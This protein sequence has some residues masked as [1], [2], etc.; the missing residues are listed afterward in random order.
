VLDP[1]EEAGQAK[2][3]GEAG[4]PE[5]SATPTASAKPGDSDDDDGGGTGLALVI[6]GVAGLA[7]GLV[8]GF[9]AMRRRR[10]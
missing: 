6:P 1:N 8:G 3:P 9:A 4:T 7:I 2:E 10:S 5:P